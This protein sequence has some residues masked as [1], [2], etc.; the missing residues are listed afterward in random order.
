[1]TKIF[2][3][4]SLSLCCYFAVADDNY[5]PLVSGFYA[6]ST[7]F[8]KDN[9][10]AKIQTG[11]STITLLAISKRNMYVSDGYGVNEYGGQFTTPIIF[12]YNVPNQYIANN[13]GC[14]AT[15]QQ[16]SATRFKISVNDTSVC[17]MSDGMF[18]A[19]GTITPKMVSN[20]F[21]LDTNLSNIQTLHGK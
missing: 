3:L 21:N 8:N 2:T 19:T 6:D 15:L 4:L 7:N 20:S 10:L 18:N 1:M 12:N 17:F 9:T 5:S 13:L 16:E 11:E 14:L